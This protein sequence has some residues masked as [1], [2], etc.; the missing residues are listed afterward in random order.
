MSINTI[1]ETFRAATEN[2]V[3]PGAVL[4][5]TNKAGTLNY[6]K[7]FGKTGVSPDAKPLT[8]DSTFWI[9]SCSKLLTTIACLQC[10]ERG[11]FSLDS[12][13][14]IARILPEISAPEIFSGVD[15]EGRSIL[16]PAKNRITLRQL[17]THTAGL[18]Y[19]GMDPRL[20]AWRK[21]PDG[22]R[23]FSD[24]FT[25]K[26]LVPLVFEPGEQWS[27]SLGVDW[28]G[29]LVERVNDG[30]TLEAYMQQHIWTPLGMRDITFHLEQKEQVKRYLVE[31]TAR[32]P[33]SGLLIQGKNEIIPDPITFESGGAGLYSSAPEYLKVLT[34]ILRDDGKLLK[35]E[36]IAEMF[37][38]QLSPTTKDSWM[39][40]LQNPFANGALTG[41]LPTGTDLTW[42]LGGK[43]SL[44][45]MDGR[46]KKG[47]LSWC[48][49]PNL[50]WWIDQEAGIAGFYASQ[51]VPTGD[52]K[53]TDLFAEFEKDVYRKAS[54]VSQ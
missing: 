18:S 29:K 48:G 31:T 45:D 37:K 28:A 25:N 39:K 21:T 54:Q 26:C 34:S 5:A 22:S 42:G 35:S 9:A 30:V 13:E 27:Y 14:D 23:T 15:S 43:Y 4:M 40:M 38:P 47:S 8:L 52:R 44:E 24:D 19:E 46:R 36:S 1:E 12:P 17:L 50:F 7:A 2:R 53:S 20:D 51:V 41:N 49:L 3:I 10:I 6:A 11:L 33:E 32:V 16:A